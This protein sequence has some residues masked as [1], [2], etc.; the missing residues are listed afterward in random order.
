MFLMIGV[1]ACRSIPS[2][3]EGHLALARTPNETQ[4]EVQVAL[5]AFSRA[6]RDADAGRLSAMLTDRYVHSNSGG[7]V[8]RKPA[9]LDYVRS[10]RK[11]LDEGALVV[12]E[13][14]N[15]NVVIETYGDAAVVHGLNVSKGTDKGK[16]FAKRIVFTH[17]WVRDGGTWKRASFHDSKVK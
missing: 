7:P 4:H 10:R 15:E 11:L 16:P 2:S 5:D 8:I 17:T 6:Y 14:E 13:Y 3:N 9:W 12:S 1:G